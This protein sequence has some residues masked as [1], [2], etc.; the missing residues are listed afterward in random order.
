MPVFHFEAVNLAGQASS[1]TLEATDR[2]DALRKLTRRGLQPSSVRAG[3]SA[4]ESTAKT[5]ATSGSAKAGKP[6]READASPTAKTSGRSAGG[7]GTGPIKLKKAQ[8]IQ[9][10]EELCDLLA[11]G[12]QLEQALHA[13][14]NRSTVLIRDLAIRLREKVRDGIPFSVSLQQVSPS[15]GELYCNLVGAG[16]ASGSL[17]SILNRQAI[18]LTQMQTLQARVTTALIYP[19]FIITS[20]LGL[21]VMFLTYLLP[22]LAVLIKS[23][24]GELPAIAVVMMA[25]SDFF[26][27]WWWALLGGVVFAIL[28]IVVLFQDKGRQ[29]WWDRV[30]LNLPLYGGVLRTRFEVQFLETLGNLLHNGLPLHRALELVRKATVNQFLR[31]RLGEVEAAVADG[32]SLS[33]ALEKTTVVRP[34]VIDMVRVGEQTG[35]LSTALQKAG[36]RFES[37]LAKAMDRA[38][39]L[40]QPVIILVM[41]SMVGTMA[42]MMI[43]VVWATLN[44]LQR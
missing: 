20:G 44:N 26:I 15:F 37:H 24:H 31:A 8:V 29:A 22:K 25:A 12:L 4:G 9:F 30:Q 1:G 23:T 34:L 40:L 33:R 36:T 13:M 42:W 3:A 35:E 17:P 6:K 39:A 5:A 18:Y 21:A 11:A 14:E 10:T 41:A 7:S 32:G 2:G 38:T 27:A 16:E 43:N 19:V 28:T